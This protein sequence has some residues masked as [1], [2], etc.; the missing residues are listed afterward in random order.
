MWQTVSP[1]VACR[2]VALTRKAMW[3][4]H[5]SEMGQK[6]TWAHFLEDVCFTPKSRHS[7]PSQS[8]S[9]LCQKR[10]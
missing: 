3:A 1:V 2:L 6:Q 10:L 4:S 9:A 8:M 7:G 5:M